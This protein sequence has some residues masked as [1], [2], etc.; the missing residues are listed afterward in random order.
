MKIKTDF[1]SNSSCA[2]FII[3]RKNITKIQEYLIR[4]HYEFT[5]KYNPN[6]LSYTYFDSSGWKITFE[7]DKIKGETIMDNFDMFWFLTE[8]GIKDENIN[9]NKGL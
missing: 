6:E 8:I 3:E 7:D 9:Y 4:N 2:S 1:V 5:K